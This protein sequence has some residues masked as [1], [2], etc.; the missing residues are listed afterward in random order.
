MSRRLSD[1]N[2][3]QSNQE[4]PKTNEKPKASH[5]TESLSGPEKPGQTIPKITV[6]DPKWTNGSIPLD[7]VPT[8][9]ARLGKVC[10]LFLGNFLS[11]HINYHLFPLIS[12][13]FFLF[14]ISP[15]NSFLF[16]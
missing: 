16:Y 14:R 6:H 15:F 2:G 9:L 10:I 12:E 8:N 11:G 13:F 3:R 4:D 1:A 5:K 7:A